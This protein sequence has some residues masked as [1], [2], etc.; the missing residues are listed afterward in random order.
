MKNKIDR[1]FRKNLID[2]IP[3]QSAREEY[4]NQGVKMI[5][6]DANENPFTSGS[7]RYPDPMQTK[8][9]NRIA[10]WKNINENQI[11]LS[12]GSD[13]SIS[14]L[15]MAFC[16][17]GIDNII[18]LPPTFGMYKV[19]AHVHGIKVKEAPLDSSFQIDAQLVL[20]K[21][22]KNSKIIFIPTPNNPTGNSFNLKS[23]ILCSSLPDQ[24]ST[25]VILQPIKFFKKK[26]ALLP[27]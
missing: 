12:N 26:I 25:Q 4:A 24:V 2:L 21:S 18:T 10:N 1:F 16:E 14:Q 19:S 8:L 27:S 6:L 20:E 17:P 22:N 15:I 13:E 7:N 23:I 5:L 3:Y 9:K 11:Y